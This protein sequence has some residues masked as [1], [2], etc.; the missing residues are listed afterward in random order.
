MPPNINHPTR[1]PESPFQAAANGI[2]MDNLIICNTDDGQSH[3][4]LLVS[5]DDTV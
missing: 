2:P 3:V 5:D 4:S 1:Q